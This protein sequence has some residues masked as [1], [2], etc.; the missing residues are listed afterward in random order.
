MTPPHGES[1]GERFE[2]LAALREE[3]LIRQLGLSNV[4]ADHLAEARGVAPIAA[5]QNS[6]HIAKRDEAAVL[7]ACAAPDLQGQFLRGIGGA[8]P[9]SSGAAQAGAT[10]R[11]GLSFLHQHA[12][13]VTDNQ[14]GACNVPLSSFP[15]QSNVRRSSPQAL[16]VYNAGASMSVAATGCNYLSGP[17]TTAG[18][19]AAAIGPGDSETRPAG[20]TI[21]GDT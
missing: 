5:V 1:L 13:R 3:G 19:D 20:D 11:N 18:A 21:E 8:E 10:A 17:A 15:G 14:G 4:D 2:V 9:A 6:F 7:D 12:E 16:W